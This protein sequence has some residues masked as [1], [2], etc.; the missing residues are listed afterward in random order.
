ML[1]GFENACKKKMLSKEAISY[2][3]DNWGTVKNI[4]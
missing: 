1:S 3:E 2:F 4:N